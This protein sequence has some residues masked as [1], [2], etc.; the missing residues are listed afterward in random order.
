MVTAADDGRPV[1]YLAP[2][3][4]SEAGCC[5][6]RS[7]PGRVR[8]GGDD[9]AMEQA[10][11]AYPDDNA[12]W[13]VIMPPRSRPRSTHRAAGADGACLAGTG[14]GRGF[15]TYERSAASV[16]SHP[17]FIR[18]S[19]SSLRFR[20]VKRNRCPESGSCPSL[21]VTSALGGGGY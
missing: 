13:P 3:P 5:D 16:R 14:V 19:C 11:I 6:S 12:T 7:S 4:C 17:W 18:T 2:I 1:M 21:R 8:G 10:G 15:D 20:F 9:G